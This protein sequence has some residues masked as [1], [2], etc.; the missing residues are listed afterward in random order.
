MHKLRE[1]QKKKEI[2]FSERKWH[3]QLLIVDLQLVIFLFQRLFH[4]KLSII[5]E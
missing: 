3:Y 2:F 4:V 1:Q 5:V